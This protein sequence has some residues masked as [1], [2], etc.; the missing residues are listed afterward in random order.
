MTMKEAMRMDLI[1]QELLISSGGSSVSLETQL[2]SLRELLGVTKNS[3]A[4]NTQSAALSM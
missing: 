3:S 1:V 2:S 4:P